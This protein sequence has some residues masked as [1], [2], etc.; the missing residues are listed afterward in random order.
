MASA[1]GST[2]RAGRAFV[3]L[4]ADDTMLVRGLK[5][6]EARVRRFGKNIH[7][8]GRRLATIGLAMS[9]PFVM[10]IK[11]FADFDDTMRAVKAVSNA[12]GDEFEMLTKKAVELGRT[13]SFTAQRCGR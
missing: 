3:E 5:R 13:T 8:I 6:A 12:T 7:D 11:T 9:I 1:S 2:I 4:F 10:S